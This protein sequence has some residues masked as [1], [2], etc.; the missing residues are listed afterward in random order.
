M[1]HKVHPKIYRI[2]KTEDWL[3]KGFYFKK[4]K[5]YL[6][7]DFKIREFLKQRIPKLALGEIEIERKGNQIKVIINT[8]R[9]G[10]I[11]G[12]KGEGVERIKRALIKSLGFS[13]EKKIDIEIVEIKKP[14]TSASFVAHWMA[15]KIESRVPYRKVLKGALSQILTNKEVKGA[16][17]QVAGRL[18]GVEIARKEWLQEGSLPRTTLRADIDFYKTEAQ[19]TYGKIGIKVWIYK[20]EKE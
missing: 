12:R 20:G 11:I 14:W 19:T 18:D 7:E 13:P 16:R 4:M 5:E 17:V 6:E 3:T 1:A 8:A 9:P 15:S 2:T 10:L